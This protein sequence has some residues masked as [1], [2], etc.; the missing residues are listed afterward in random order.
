[1]TRIGI[2]LTTLLVFCISPLL[3]QNKFPLE[4]HRADAQKLIN[5]ALS[6]E[7]S[8]DELT[9][10]VDTFGHRFSGSKS[11]ERSIDWIMEELKKGELENVHTQ[12]VMVPRWVRGS[13]YAAM[14][15]PRKKELPML[16][17]G[18]SIGTPQK[19]VE[20]E[21]LVVNSFKDLKAK[22]KQAKGKIVL[23]DVPFTT[24]GET[25][26]YRVSG[27]VEAA[28]VGAVASLIRSVGPFSMKTPHTGNSRYQQGVKKIPHAAITGED[29]SLLHRLQKRGETVR[30]QLYMEARTLPDTKSRNIVAEIRGSEK[31]EEIVVLGGHIDSWDLGQ[32]AMDDAGGC[33]A[34]WE[35]LKLMNELGLRPRR[36]VRLVMWTNEENGLR[37][38]KK[39]RDLVKEN[40][41]LHNHILAMESDGG[42]FT[43]KGF[44][45][46]GSDEAYKII[47][48]IGSLLKPIGADEITRGGGGADISPLMKEGI[49][50]MGL[51]VD[52]SRYFWYHHTAADTIDKLSAEEYKKCVATMAVMAY[53]VANMDQ[54]LPKQH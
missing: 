8:F 38:A 6:D 34:A 35:A 11:L 40:G 10:F 29:A 43:P 30:V 46:S 42:V 7:T 33:F 4:N 22:A 13:E 14:T 26:Q 37:G 21:V 1:M 27:A 44:G 23:Y 3:A 16:G 53:S 17:L 45:F 47:K 39:Y 28:K 36:T 15:A 19:G 52:G 50:G 31:P 49:P 24:Y 51:R 32:G 5:A 20:A 41:T 18:S 48:K 9:Y 25:V 12:E 54:T 2:L